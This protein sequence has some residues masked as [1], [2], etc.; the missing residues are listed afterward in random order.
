[1]TGLFPVRHADHRRPRR[2]AL[3]PDHVRDGT[4]WRVWHG[5]QWVFLLEGVADRDLV[6]VVLYVVLANRPSEAKWLSD[7][8]KA[9]GAD[10]DRR[11]T[12]AGADDRASHGKL[13]AALADPR[14]WVLAF[15][16][17]ACA[18]AVYTMTF[19]LPTM[20]KLLGVTDVVQIGWYT[21]LPYGFGALGII[22]LSLSSDRFP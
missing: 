11:P 22:L 13:R 14:T 10:R 19:W 15:I 17:F 1:M 7:R 18:A 21:V 4:G 3:G 9:V 16:Y 8:E 12:A 6:G 5:W 20:V 2:A